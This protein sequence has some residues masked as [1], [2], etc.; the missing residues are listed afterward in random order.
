MIFPHCSHG[1]LF[2]WAPRVSQ[3]NYPAVCLKSKRNKIPDMVKRSMLEWRVQTGVLPIKWD[4]G[5]KRCSGLLAVHKMLDSIYCEGVV[6]CFILKCH[7]GLA[8]SLHFVWK[9]LFCFW[10]SVCRSWCSTCFTLLLSLEW[11]VHVE[12]EGR[13][14]WTYLRSVVTFLNIPLSAESVR[15]N[16]FILK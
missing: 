16:S 5:K 10:K 7:I 15:R 2:Q 8:G 11:E 9:D 1:I 3:S 12:V 13:A 4:H 14:G 6:S